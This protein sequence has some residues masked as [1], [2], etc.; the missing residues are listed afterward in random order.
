MNIS[1]RGMSPIIIS[2]ATCIDMLRK[3]K[4]KWP[5]C[6]M[7][8]PM[9]RWVQN[10]TLNFRKKKKKDFE[11]SWYTE[12]LHSRIVY[13]RQN[14]TNTTIISIR[15]AVTLA[16][17]TFIQ[18]IVILG[19]I[20]ISGQ[21]YT[22]TTIISITQAITLKGVTFIQ[23]IVILSKVV[24]SGQ[25]YTNT[26]II[27]L[28]PAITLK[29]VTFIQ[30]IVILSKVVISGSS[31]KTVCNLNRGVWNKVLNFKFSFCSFPLTGLA[32]M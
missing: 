31:L 4:R 1:D 8:Y 2:A 29:G 18:A 28:T 11:N 20:V 26:T 5:A 22:N 12:W 9:D 13:N 21:N 3:S 6:N 32:L 7:F 14:Y 25:N 23:A 24:I 27:S 17:V 16:H 10:T 15:P 19:K 30:A